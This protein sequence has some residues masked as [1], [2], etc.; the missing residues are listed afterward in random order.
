MAL[1]LH[2]QLW[3]QSDGSTE[4]GLSVMCVPSSDISVQHLAAS[5]NLIIPSSTCFNILSHYHLLTP[6]SAG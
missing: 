4:C 6:R 3:P 5:I 2:T 1:V